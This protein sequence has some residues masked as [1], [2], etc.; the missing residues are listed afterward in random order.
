MQNP[1]SVQKYVTK[2]EF[3]CRLLRVKGS[4]FL[5]F[6]SIKLRKVLPS[7]KSKTSNETT[8]NKGNAF[9]QN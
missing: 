4:T 8:Q 3:N 6:N 1:K 5:L 9:Q 2:K 7:E